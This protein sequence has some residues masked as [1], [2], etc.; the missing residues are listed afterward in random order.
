MILSIIMNPNIFDNE[1]LI[2]IYIGT[3]FALTTLGLVLLES[4]K[5]PYWFKSKIFLFLGAAS[6]SI[7]L[8]H[9]PA[10]SVLNRVAG[11]INAA[12]PG[13]P[14][15]ILFL[16]ATATA[17]TAGIAYYILWEKPILKLSKKTLLPQNTLNKPAQAKQV[18]S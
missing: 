15:E 17:T 4:Q 6:Y 3:G 18:A 7:Y 13:I 8:I 14:A 12:Y 1:E 16:F 2:T 5:K 11:R 9:N 10:L